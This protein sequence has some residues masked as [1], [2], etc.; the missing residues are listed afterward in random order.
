MLEAPQDISGGIVG[1]REKWGHGFGF[2]HLDHLSSAS[3]LHAVHSSRRP[4]QLE[5]TDN[6][7]IFWLEA[8]GG[9]ATHLDVVIETGSGLGRRGNLK[10]RFFRRR[11][12]FHLWRL[13]YLRAL[14]LLARMQVARL[15]RTPGRARSVC[16]LLV[17]LI[18]TAICGG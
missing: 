14:V 4:Q 1:Q 7:R 9:G 5:C 12:R 8:W 17:V 11:T 2:S 10:I 3:R 16:P 15:D 6:P 18:L 13:S